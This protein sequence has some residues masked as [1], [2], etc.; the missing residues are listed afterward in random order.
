M[1]NKEDNIEIKENKSKI[2][3][4]QEPFLNS[5]QLEESLKVEEK[6]DEQSEELATAAL[7]NTRFKV[8]KIDFTM[9]DQSN[10]NEKSDTNKKDGD[11]KSSTNSSVNGSEQAGS[12]NEY[13]TQY[14][15]SL[16]HY[17]R[18]PLPK[19]SVFLICV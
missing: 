10:G 7:K 13:N 2:V 3:D 12:E 16:R 14:L 15:K 19:V 5:E 17:T 1:D 6:L 9:K 11:R 8:K 4:F 18:E